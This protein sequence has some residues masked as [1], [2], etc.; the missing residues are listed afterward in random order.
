M[1]L[2]VSPCRRIPTSHH[3]FGYRARPPFI[4]IQPPRDPGPYWL[5]LNSARKSCEAGLDIYTEREDVEHEFLLHL[6]RALRELDK[7]DGTNDE[8][9]FGEADGRSSSGRLAAWLTK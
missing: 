2:R 4:T 8:R 9:T 5:R 6:A 3:R 1:K 7:R